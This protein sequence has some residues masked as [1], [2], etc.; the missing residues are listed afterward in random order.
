MA[1]WKNTTLSIDT[2]LVARQ[3]DILNQA[4]DGNWEEKHPIAKRRIGQ[5][6]R[7]DL[8]DNVTVTNVASG[9]DGVF[10]GG[11]P[12]FNSATATFLTGS[13][14]V[15]SGHILDVISEVADRGS[16]Y[17]GAVTDGQNVSVQDMFGVARNFTENQT[18][19]VYQIRPDVLDS[20]IN[21]EDALKDAAVSLTLHLVY[22]DL[23]LQEVQSDEYRTKK[24]LF[25]EQFDAHLE[26][27]K[28]NLAIL[29]SGVISHPFRRSVTKDPFLL[30]V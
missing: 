29:I 16:Y 26:E 28:Q 20:I 11:S 6:L 5:M 8:S 18:V 22:A 13:T 27:G 10:N 25:S 30:K 14:P 4:S 12:T 7:D 24:Q 17:V 1:T 15:M 23:L 2:D 21:A 3:S 19:I 9:S